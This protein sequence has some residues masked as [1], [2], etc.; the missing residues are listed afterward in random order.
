[1]LA[2]AARPGVSIEGYVSSPQEAEGVDLSRLTFDD[3]NLAREIGRNAVSGDSRQWRSLMGKYSLP[4][5]RT[6]LL[7]RVNHHG[8]VEAVF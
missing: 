5:G 1:M 6:P 2:A 7:L 4:G 8:D 3:P